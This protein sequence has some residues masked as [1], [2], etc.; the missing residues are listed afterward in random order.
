MRRGVCLVSAVLV[1]ICIDAIAQ[2]STPELTQLAS[3]AAIIFRG[4]VI[5]VEI[6]PARVPDEI[7]APR[8]TLRV[9]DSVRGAARGATITIRQWNAAPDEYRVGESLVLFLHAPSP[10]LGLT[11]PVGGRAGHLRVD[12]V[13]EALLDSL[14]VTTPQVQLDLFLPP[15]PPRPVRSRTLRG[16]YVEADQ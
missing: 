16:R 9:K 11:S 1:L 3:S 4:E 13:P 7:A 8:I 2:Q 6:E 14:R 10:E 12:Q 5:S 15:P